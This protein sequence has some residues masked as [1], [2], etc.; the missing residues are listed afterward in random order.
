MNLDQLTQAV[1]DRLEKDRPRAL[2]L[3]KAPP[4]DGGYL[5]VRQAPYEAVVL[6]LLSPGEL[7]Q[8]PTDSVCQALLEEKPVYLW[9]QQPYRQAKTARLLCRELAAAE[10]HLK[11]LGVRPMAQRGRLITAQDAQRLRRMGKEPPPG[12]RMTPLAR[13][14]MEGTT[15]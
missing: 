7:L 11:Q 13:E 3:G 5:L 2:L 15:Q 10:Q 1:L 12:C 6:G 9:P 4:E 14:I 8:M